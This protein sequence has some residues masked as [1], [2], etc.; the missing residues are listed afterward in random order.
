ML[1]L[2]VGVWNRKGKWGAYTMVAKLREGKK[3]GVGCFSVQ[4]G[5]AAYEEWKKKT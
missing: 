3:I 5:L 2:V 1:L 4:W